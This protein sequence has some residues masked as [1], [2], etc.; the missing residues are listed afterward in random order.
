[1]ADIKS[2]NEIKV[3]IQTM[4]AQYYGTP[5]YITETKV[6]DL[7]HLIVTL[8]NGIQYDT[9][10]VKGEKGDSFKY[11][12]F[13]SEQLALLKGEKGDRGFSG[14]YVGSGEMPE[15]YNVQIDETE[16]E[17]SWVKSL[18]QG[19]P[20]YAANISSCV[21]TSRMYVL[22]DGYIYSYYTHEVQIPVDMFDASEITY[23]R[24]ITGGTGNIVEDQ[25]CVG[26]IVTGYIPLDNF[27]TWSSYI[28]RFKNVSEYFVSGLDTT[29]KHGAYGTPY[30]CFYDENKTYLGFILLGNGKSEADGDSYII[31]LSA[32]AI[33]G[34][35]TW[36]NIKATAKYLRMSFVPNGYGVYAAPSANITGFETYIDSSNLPDVK[37]SF[38]AVYTVDVIPAWGNTGISYI[39]SLS[40]S[41]S[42]E[43]S[44]L[45]QFWEGEV[46][47]AIDNV[48]TKQEK[49][50]VNCIN[51]ALCADMH[52]ENTSGYQHCKNLGK[53]ASKVLNECNIP[54]LIVAG[55][56]NSGAGII[57]ETSECIYK[58]IEMQDEILKP[59]GKERILKILGNHDG[60]W[61]QTTAN[62]TTL[63]YDRAISM[64]ER[65]NLFMAPQ[66]DLKRVW[67]D[68]G[69]Y[70]YIDM[71]QK[72]AR[73]ICLNS[74]DIEY[75]VGEDYYSTDTPIKNPMKNGNGYGI[76][77]L[78]WL[79]N[80]A[81]DVKDGWSI[82]L[83]THIPPTLV[84]S[85][86]G[87]KGVITNEDILRGI[88]T[89]YCNKTAYSK[90]TFSVDYTNAKGE[91][92]GIFAGHMHRDAV[93]TETLPCPI[94]MITSAGNTP[95]DRSGKLYSR[96]LGTANETALDVV[97]VDTVN[98][99]VYCTR[100][101]DKSQLSGMSDRVIEYGGNI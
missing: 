21:D 24:R 25:Y 23:N 59:V 62:G 63:Y 32:L 72:K 67:G 96:Q 44:E 8:S 35:K 98:K 86:V 70:Y 66:E 71:P 14:V 61:G 78:E 83:T 53:I 29:N 36:A 77:Q 73:I 69:T 33:G 54:F 47:T 99:K 85:L 6:N 46:S 94:I 55:D 11:S 27:S 81:L 7:N 97:S 51:F 12:D 57:S 9:G 31:N 68:N 91:I 58:D 52:V 16:D 22:P 49:I 42:E 37:I 50:G 40:G 2:F 18:I 41:S 60:V 64:E 38:D 84:T 87:L 79:S 13:T 39:P 5:I 20:K 92:V 45:P 74:Q 56:N 101:G 3:K 1:M 88:I 65:F 28:M 90:N 4:L 82:I 19:Q 17:T 26:S 76:A 80:V 75:H 89:A 93:D 48:K 30:I 100:I 95:F 10:Y 15:G 43:E 34:G